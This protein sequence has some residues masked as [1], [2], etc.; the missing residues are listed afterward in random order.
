[1]IVTR[2]IRRRDKTLVYFNI[3]ENLTDKTVIHIN[4]F[5]RNTLRKGLLGSLEGQAIPMFLNNGRTK[6]ET[7]F[8]GDTIRQ[9]E[10]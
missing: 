8:M 7:T 10:R 3:E 1:M 6:I 5:C 4:T 2:M 9:V